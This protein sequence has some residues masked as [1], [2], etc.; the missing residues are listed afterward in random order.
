MD[1]G[2]IRD[3]FDIEFLLRKGVVLPEMSLDKVRG[4]RR[5]IEGLKEMDFKVKLGSV[6]ESDIREYYVTQRLGFLKEKLGAI[7]ER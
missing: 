4:I 7:A 2:E 1:R 6:L 3:G 5:K